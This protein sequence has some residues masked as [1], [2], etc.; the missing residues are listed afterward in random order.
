M[1]TYD[2]K[3]TNDVMYSFDM[4]Q[5]DGVTF[6]IGLNLTAANIHK[7]VGEFLGE[8]Y[9][10]DNVVIFLRKLS[11]GKKI[12]IQIYSGYDNNI[13]SKISELLKAHNIK[14]S[15]HDNKNWITISNSIPF[16]EYLISLKLK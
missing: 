3:T 16:I 6:R 13:R 11:S 4:K 10:G 5:N 14:F 9:D 1:K 15:F 8:L 2:E 12:S 7:L